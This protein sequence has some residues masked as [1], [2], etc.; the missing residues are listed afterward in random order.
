MLKDA[1]ITAIYV[2]EYKRTQ[3]TAAPLAAALNVTPV[4][5]K[6]GDVALLIAQIKQRSGNVLVVGHSNTVPDIIKSLG[7]TTP[8]TIADA[9]YDN[10]FLINAADSP[11]L[12]RLRFH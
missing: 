10:L 2:T 11:A 12:V 5:V 8:V 9:E 1:G 4:I 3:Q 6:A 7:V